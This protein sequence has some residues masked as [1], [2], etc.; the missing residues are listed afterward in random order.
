MPS[1]AAAAAAAATALPVADATS[2]GS[3]SPAIESVRQSQARY[4]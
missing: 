1:A 4:Y 2:G 3:E